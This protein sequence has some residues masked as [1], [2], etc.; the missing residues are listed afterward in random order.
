MDTKQCKEVA[1]RR[2]EILLSDGTSCVAELIKQDWEFFERYEI[3]IGCYN[4]GHFAD[5]KSA[6]LFYSTI[7]NQFKIGTGYESTILLDSDKICLGAGQPVIDVNLAYIPAQVDFEDET[8]MEPA[9]IIEMENGNSGVFEDECVARFIFDNLVND[10]A[11][12]E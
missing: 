11:T 4:W 5:L 7:L 3:V 1:I 6:E 8:I 10:Y 2:D 12:S 9:F